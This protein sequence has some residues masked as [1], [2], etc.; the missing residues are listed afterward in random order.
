MTRQEEKQ[1]LRRTVRQME[2]E[3]PP[4]YRETSAQ[5]IGELVQSLGLWRDAECVCCF[6]GTEREIDTRPILQA[7]LDAGKRLCVPLC[8]GDGAMEMREIPSLDALSPGTLGIPEPPL[9]APAVPPDAID[10]ILIPCLTCNHRGE[11]LGQGGGYYDR[12][13]SGYVGAAVVLCRERLVRR[14]IPV[15]AHDTAVP[16]VLTERGLFEDS[17]P[18]PLG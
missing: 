18:A 3:L 7:A 5:R 14:E 8:L 9:D 15:E 16:Y 6:V 2:R 1:V 13:L 10:L 12:F 11:R 4:R 17:A